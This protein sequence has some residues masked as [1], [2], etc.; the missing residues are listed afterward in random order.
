VKLVLL[1]RPDGTVF[2]VYSDALRDLDLGPQRI[3]RASLLEF[4]ERVQ[5]WV[6]RHVNGEVLAQGTDRRAVEAREREVLE[7]GL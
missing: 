2:T 6:A 1:L 7:A 4:D 5:E 3:S